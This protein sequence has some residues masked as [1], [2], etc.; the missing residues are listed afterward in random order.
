MNSYAIHCKISQC[1]GTQVW[2]VDAP[3]ADEARKRF[4]GGW[5]R[6]ESEN[7]QVAKI[8]VEKIELIDSTPSDSADKTP[9]PPR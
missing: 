1:E 3:N 5:A 7:F 6:L 2:T 8:E 9:R 4:D